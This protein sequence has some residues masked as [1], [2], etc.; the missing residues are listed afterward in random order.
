MHGTLHDIIITEQYFFI[1]HYN[2][3]LFPYKVLSS[4]YLPFK[5][6]NG[7]HRGK[8]LYIFLHELIA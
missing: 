7:A 3:Q 1:A 5:K 2:F 6:L 4:D 8:A